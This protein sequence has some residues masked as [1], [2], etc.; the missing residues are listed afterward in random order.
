MEVNGKTSNGLTA[1]DI[2]T[3]THRALK[4]M[5]IAETLR[6]ANAVRARNKKTRRTDSCY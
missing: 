1:L 5:D 4:D 6:A 3:Q 2:L